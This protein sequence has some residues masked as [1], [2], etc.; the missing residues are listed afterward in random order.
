M[1]PEQEFIVYA[2]VKNEG[3]GISSDNI[4]L[5]YYLST[6]SDIDATDTRI[7]YD[8]P[9]ALPPEDISQ[10][11]SGVQLAPTTEGIYW[12]GACVESDTDY[13]CSVG[14]QINVN[15]PI[16]PL[17]DAVDNNTCIAVTTD[18]DVDWCGQTINSHDGSDSAQSGD[19][20]DYENSGME[21]TVTG[22]MTMTFWWRVSSEYSF[23]KLS[24][25]RLVVKPDGHKFRFPFRTV[26]IHYVGN[27]KKIP[28][29]QMERTAG[30]LIR[31]PVQQSTITH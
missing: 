25:M 26:H 17:D 5:R 4:V 31:Y 20:D 1:T 7:A 22:P 30:G 18:G 27:T 3:T 12:V 11:D 28:A 24:K 9:K 16:Y 21:T 23:D 2:T 13:N 15:N 6:N 8:Y 19:I 10:H 29:Y 14:V